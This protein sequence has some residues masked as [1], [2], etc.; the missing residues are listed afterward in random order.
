[1]RYSTN[2]DTSTNELFGGTKRAS[3]R[4][5]LTLN[6][7]ILNQE[8]RTGLFPPIDS[9]AIANM[10]DPLPITSLLKREEEQ[11]LAS[12]RIFFEKNSWHSRLSKI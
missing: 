5:S 6:R 4:H 11:N 3:T 12:D 8:E 9:A 7:H 2:P 10:P 1:M